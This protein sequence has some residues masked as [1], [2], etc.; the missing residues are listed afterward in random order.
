MAGT[1]KSTIARTV[2][3]NLNGQHRLVVSFFF[4]SKGRGE[5]EGE[6]GADFTSLMLPR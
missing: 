4:F 5:R 1:G 6:L 2:L 3:Q